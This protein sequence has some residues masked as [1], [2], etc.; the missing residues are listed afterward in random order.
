MEHDRGGRQAVART[1][2]REGFS[3]STAY[4][5]RSAG[6]QDVIRH[7]IEGFVSLR[8]AATHLR[9]DTLFCI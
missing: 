8:I 5:D 3:R 6:A 2:R 1:L 7:M 4:T 9:F